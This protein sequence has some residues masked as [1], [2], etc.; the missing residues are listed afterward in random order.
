M[1]A[2]PIQAREPGHAPMPSPAREHRGYPG[3]NAL[4]ALGALMVLTTHTGFDTGRI[5]HGWFGAVIT[6][7]DFGVAIFFVLSGF[8]LGRPFLLRG[9]LG[10]PAPRLRSYFWKRALRILPLYWVV[11]LATIVFQPGNDY[12][13]PAMWARNFTLTQL[14]HPDLLPQGLTQMW[15]LATEAAFYVVLPFLCMVLIGR[16]GR[17]RSQ[18]RPA[19]VYVILG[20]ISALGVAWQAHVAPIPGVHGHYAQ[21][22]PGYLPWFAVGL[23]LATA[24]VTEQLGRESAATRFCERLASDPLGCWLAAALVYGICCT[25]LIGPRTLVAQTSWEGGLKCVLYAVSSGLLVLPLVFGHMQEHP[26]RRWCN[27]PLPFFLGEISYGIFCIH[28][29]VLNAVLRLP[30]FGIFGGHFAAVWV[31]TATVTIGL[32]TLSYYGIERPFLRL[33]SVGLGSD[34]RGGTRDTL[35]ET[36]TTAASEATS[37]S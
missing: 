13:T 15:S 32:A 37:R 25:P 11:I 1:T 2:A 34:R 14:Y 17:G 5:L 8:L 36:G 3:L 6:R 27:R 21:W 28:L 12:V 23:A 30:Q 26:I 20:I 33:K 29:L 4:R 9:A 10:Q 7:M 22:L 31:I 16:R 18:L 35:A 19:R 24:S